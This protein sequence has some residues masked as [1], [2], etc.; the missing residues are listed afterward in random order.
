MS[1]TPPYLSASELAESLR[2][3]LSQ[4][5]RAARRGV[6]PYERTLGG[7]YLFDE[8]LVIA[9]LRSRPGSPPRP[10]IRA[11]LPDRIRRVYV[12][13]P[14][15]E[16]ERCE[17]VIARVREA[18]IAVTCDWTPLVRAWLEAGSPERPDEALLAEGGADLAGVA[19]ADAVLLLTPATPGGAGAGYWTEQGAALALRKPV[20]LSMGPTPEATGQRGSPVFAVFC[21]IARTDKAALRMLRERAPSATVKMHPA[22]VAP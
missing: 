12:A 19:A 1:S 16:L 6:I 7:Q 11:P 10:Y 15:A 17:K 22:G 20:I 5:R 4:I 3:P 8:P 9:A 18:G 21:H 13:G 14:S 2:L